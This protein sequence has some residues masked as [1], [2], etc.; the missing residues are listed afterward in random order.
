MAGFALLGYVVVV[1]GSST[2]WK[3]E[4]AWWHSMVVWFVAAFV[5]HDLVMFPVYALLDRALR[6]SATRRSPRHRPAVPVLNY[7]RVP[8]LGSGLLFLIFFPGIIRQGATLFGEDTGLTQEPFLG[9]WLMLTAL[10]FGF[11][12]VAYGVRLMIVMSAHNA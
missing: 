11:S 5:L 4:G 1:A 12:A 2:L 3:P 6:S 8:A 7:L 10:L 9:R